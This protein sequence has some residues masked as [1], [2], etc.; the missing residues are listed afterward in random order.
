[1]APAKSARSCVTPHRRSDCSRRCSSTPTRRRI[2]SAAI[3]R[4]S[5][6]RRSKSAIVCSPSSM[7]SSS[8]D[9]RAR[10]DRTR[11]RDADRGGPRRRADRDSGAR[12]A[13]A[14]RRAR[15]ARA[16]SA[17]G[18]G[19][20]LEQAGHR[21]PSVFRP[22]ARGARPA[23]RSPGDDDVGARGDLSG[24]SSTTDS[25]AVRA[26]AVEA[27]GRGPGSGS[28]R[29]SWPEHAIS[30]K[31]RRSSSISC[32][33]WTSDRVASSSLGWPRCTATSRASCC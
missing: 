28:A 20:A 11:S 14:T 30:R 7:A 26:A 4:R 32:T 6:S 3:R 2:S 25:R 1:M 19:D 10:C 9:A 8:D 13:R 5:S 29:G 31:R 18:C 15:T 21:C 22:T 33:A 17:C 24:L 16:R 12:V 23:C 27:G